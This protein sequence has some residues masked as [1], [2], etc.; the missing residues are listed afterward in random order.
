LRYADAGIDNRERDADAR[1]VFVFGFR[2][3]GDG[4]LSGEL[5]AIAQKVH[6][7]LI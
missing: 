2:A 5:V 3:D 4:T 7:D 1:V 6:E